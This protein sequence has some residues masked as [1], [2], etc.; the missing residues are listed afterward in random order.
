[1]KMMMKKMN[2]KLTNELADLGLHIEES[3]DE[4][5]KAIDFS[6]T[7]GYKSCWVWGN[8]PNDLEV[9]CEHPI[10]EFDDDETVGECPVC[11]ATCDWHY[12]SYNDDGYTVSDRIPHQW[13]N[14][15][16]IGGLVSKIIEDTK[17]NG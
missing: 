5:R 1:M 17:Y 12:E 4:D 2:K 9:D 14:N 3:K 13:H 10:V 7:D 15:K 6:I 8:K 16:E 11:G